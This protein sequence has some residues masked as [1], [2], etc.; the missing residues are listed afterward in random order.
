MICIMPTALY[1]NTFAFRLTNANAV[2]PYCSTDFDHMIDTCMHSV[3]IGS[4]S[5]HEGTILEERSTYN[6]SC[7]S[8]T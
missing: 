6:R 5:V 8:R 2:A 3:A 7:T 1:M 4:G